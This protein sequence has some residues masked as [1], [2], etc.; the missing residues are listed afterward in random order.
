MRM[1]FYQL[2]RD[3]VEAVVTLLAQ[4]VLAAGKRGLVVSGDAD[5]RAAIGTA[6]WAQPECF[7]ANG[8]AGDEHAAR[9]PLLLS[10]N[11]EAA[12]G[13]TNV[14]LADGIWREESEAFARTFLL[15]DDATV[16]AA[17][18]LWRKLDGREGL[19]RNFW[20]QD[21]GRWTK[22]A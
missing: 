4:K 14:L 17:R 19:E 21:G 7:L 5:Q 13:A 15:F 8:E 10:A 3:P 20:K 11:C 16:D 18:E 1:D 12:N 2:S 9:Q 6:L 22:A